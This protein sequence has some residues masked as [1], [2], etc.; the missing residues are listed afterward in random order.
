MFIVATLLVPGLHVR[1]LDPQAAYHV[2]PDLIPRPAQY[3]F[4][5]V[6]LP[7]RIGSG[8]V[9]P[10]ETVEIGIAAGGVGVPYRLLPES[11]TVEA[12]GGN[13]WAWTA[14]PST[15]LVRMIA[16]DSLGIDTMRIHAFVMV[17]YEEI[18]NGVLRGHRIGEYPGVREIGGIMYRRPRGF[19]AVDDNT[20]DAR[21]SPHFALGQFAGNPS[22]GSNG[23]VVLDP[24]L[25]AKLEAIVEGLGRAGHRVATLGIMSGYRTPAYNRAHGNARYSRHQ[26]GDAA[27]FFVD[28]DGDGRMDD[29]N[30]DK[31]VNAADAGVL[32]CVIENLAVD[33]REDILPGGLGTY[34][35]S[36]MHGPFVHTDARGFRT[37]WGVSA[38]CVSDPGP[39]AAARP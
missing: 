21:V 9:L 25:V 8:F 30:G 23:Y 19:I 12:L 11:G 17:P 39:L 10:N 38:G 4:A 20:R 13:R 18:K 35:S 31:R 3:A 5:G 6:R 26:Y 32:Q 22:G 37:R 1:E 33:S 2:D 34:R 16:V 15:G 28:A 7:H 36:V 14:P 29:L 24:A 27:D